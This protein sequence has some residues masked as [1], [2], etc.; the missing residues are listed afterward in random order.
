[1]AT[2]GSVRRRD[3]PPLKGRKAIVTWEARIPHPS[4]LTATGNPVTVT[5]THATKA[6]A[7]I[8]LSGKRA[9]ML[10]TMGIVTGSVE[11]DV[12]EAVTRWLMQVERDGEGK[13]GQVSSN[14]MK[15]Y[16]ELA[17]NQVLAGID[18]V[19]D[20]PTLPVRLKT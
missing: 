3:Y 9:E 20:I 19:P 17:R 12:R 5:K 13:R 1:M 6:E 7:E 15:S 16:R 10:A 18:G 8:W 2:R 14:T 11:M 4:R